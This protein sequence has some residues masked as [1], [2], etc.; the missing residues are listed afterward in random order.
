M[1][2]ELVGFCQALVRTIFFRIGLLAESENSTNRS[3]SQRGG[4]KIVA[5]RQACKGQIHFFQNDFHSPRF[6]KAFKDLLFFPIF[7]ICIVV[8]SIPLHL[9]HILSTT[10]VI[11]VDRTE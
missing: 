3:W 8:Y 1:V 7:R 5:P 9:K 10:F 11:A 6:L 2:T 4:E